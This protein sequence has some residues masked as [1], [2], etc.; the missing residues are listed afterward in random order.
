MRYRSY[1]V[2][3]VVGMSLIAGGAVSANSYA[4]LDKKIVAAYNSEPKLTTDVYRYA[5]EMMEKS[6]RDSSR[7]ADAWQ[8]KAEKLVTI[9][10]YMEVDKA[11][12]NNEITSAYVWALRGISNGSSRGDI[13]NV[14]IKPLYD[15]LKDTVERLKSN[16][17]VK[18][19]KY[20]STQRMVRDYRTVPKSNKVFPEDKK[21]L[22]GRR[23]ERAEDFTLEEGPSQDS[24]GNMYVIVRF[25]FGG[26]LEIR[27]FTGSG[28]RGI[29]LPDAGNMK[30]YPSWQECARD[31]AQVK[32]LQGI[33]DPLV[34]PAPSRGKEY[35]VPAGSGVKKND[36]HKKGHH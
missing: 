29:N 20:A 9:A 21:D 15:Y 4:D 24:S 12:M 18:E 17:E 13:G 23:V 10:C 3:V 30:Y 11:M 5:M 26:R 1:V 34:K 28:W 31:N 8:D 19:L 2:I 14:N 32:R 33:Q 27:Y 16:S 35:Y 36:E 7:D 25:N 22:T 6:Q